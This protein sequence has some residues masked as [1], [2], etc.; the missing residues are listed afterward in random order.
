MASAKP[1]IV[2]LAGAWHSPPYFAKITSLLQDHLYVV[3]TRQL[4]SVGVPPLWT[5][6]KDFVQDTVAVRSL[7]DYAV[8][9]GNDVVV[10]CHSWGGTV[11]GGALVGYSKEERA[12]NGLQGGVVRVGYMCAFMIDEGISLHE[13]G[14]GEYPPWYDR[15]VGRILYRSPCDTELLQ[16]PYI[17][18]NDPSVMYNGLSEAEQAYWFSQLQTHSLCTIQAPTLGAS[19]KTIPSSYLMCEKDLAIPLQAQEMMVDA[20]REKGAQV[21]VSRLETGHSPY[22]TMPKE[23]VDWIRTVAGEET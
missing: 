22:L 16:G 8:G 9:E 14:G 17:R 5:P 2:L 3:H 1:H 20:A 7:L 12:K 23:T 13:I 11:A 18:V 15:N 4:P 19:W 10:I 6:P 21:E